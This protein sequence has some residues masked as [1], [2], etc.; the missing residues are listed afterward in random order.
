MKD[1]FFYLT[2]GALIGIV[3]MQWAMPSGQATIV[4]EPISGI[5]AL[6]PPYIV[7]ENGEFWTIDQFGNFYQNPELTLP[8]PTEQ[9]QFIES[10]GNILLW[11]V[12]KNGNFWSRGYTEDFWVN[13]G[14]PDPSVQNYSTS[15]G[16]I[17]SNYRGENQ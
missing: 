13:H 15:W 2:I 17:K 1:R 8:I 4:T 10:S 3:V 11:M 7:L 5:V 6:A 12:D 9:V 14:N 16:K